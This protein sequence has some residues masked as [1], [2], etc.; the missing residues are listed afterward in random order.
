MFSQLSTLIPG[1]DL[2]PDTLP[3]CNSIYTSYSTLAV[4]LL[5]EDSN[6]CPGDFLTYS[7]L[8]LFLRRQASPA[9]VIFVGALQSYSHYQAVMKKLVS[10]LIYIRFPIGAQ[11]ADIC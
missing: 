9:T 1:F 8:E 10:L 6:S 7:V 4:R 3:P 2:T 11:L 5:L